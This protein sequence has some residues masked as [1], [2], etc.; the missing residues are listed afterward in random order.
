[1]ISERQKPTRSEQTN[2]L[3]ALCQGAAEGAV[4][5]GVA[6]EAIESREAALETARRQFAEGVEVELESNPAARQWEVFS[7]VVIVAFDEQR[8][9]LAVLK[10]ALR[11]KGKALDDAMAGLIT[12]TQR[13]FV[14]TEAYEARLVNEGSS[15]HPLQNYIVNMTEAYKRGDLARESYDDIL[16]HGRGYFQRCIGEMRNAPPEE[17]REAISAL[18]EAFT[19]CDEGLASLESWAASGDNARLDSGL[20]AFEEGQAAV[21]EGFALHRRLRYESGP[22][23]SPIANTFINAARLVAQGQYPLET[24][25]NDLAV[26]R[27]HLARLRRGFEGACQASTNS[28]IIQDEI[29]RA[30]EA[31]DLHEEAVEAYERYCTTR[32]PADIETGTTQLVEAIKRLEQ[33]KLIFDQAS[34]REGKVAC[35]RCGALNGGGHRVCGACNAALPWVASGAT[36][37]FAIQ[38]GGEVDSAAGDLVLTE[39]M[40]RVINDTNRVA[41]GEITGEQYAATLDWM[42]GI[43]A[44]GRAALQSTPDL[45]VDSFPEEEREQAKLEKGLIDET[46]ESLAQA[47]QSILDSL[48]ELRCFIDDGDQQHLMKGLVE[49]WEASQQVH[50]VQRIGEMAARAAE[51]SA[52][53]PPPVAEAGEAPS[54]QE[55]LPSVSIQGE[56][57]ESTGSADD[58]LAER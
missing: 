2:Q 58:G 26:L 57:F 25:K 56:S 15:A 37:S 6:R 3:L 33:S 5:E 48:E 7:R 30:M 53:A 41:A 23:S 45:T 17:P 28:S 4:E 49:F 13:L 10:G 19:R 46:R 39:N 8:K 50:R 29:P 40:Y 34:E 52:P 32:N 11:H 35:P 16:R 18:E 47:M 14:A 43:V 55:T 44:E 38:E 51:S 9:A 24:F 21:Q 27:E 31:L 20:A 12:A 1:M 36:T 54:D 22:T 42:A